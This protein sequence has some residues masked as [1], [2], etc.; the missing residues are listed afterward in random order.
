ME[1]TIIDNQY[2]N[3]SHGDGGLKTKELLDNLFFPL[4]SNRWLLKEEDS[5]ILKFGD[6]HLAF[7][8]DSFVVSPLVFPGG[9]IGKLA[10]C[11]TV[12]DLIMCGANP[13]YLSAS[14]IIPE[15][16][17]MKLLKEMVGSLAVLA[18]KHSIPV[19]TGDTKVTE[20]QNKENLFINTTGIG[21]IEDDYTLNMER[22]EPDDVVI[23]TGP[24]GDHGAAIMAARMDIG[25]ENSPVSDCAPLLSLL[26]SLSTYSRHIKLMRDP[27]RGG[28]AT[29]LKEI[30]LKGNVDMLIEETA[31]PVNPKVRAVSEILGLDPLYL[32]CEGRALVIV[33]RTSAP[34]IL[35]E[36]MR[37]NQT[38][39]ACAIGKVHKGNGNLLIK[40]RLGGTRRLQML[41]GSPLP[42]IC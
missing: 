24:I 30:C 4:L 17:E 34:D 3:L 9:N 5:A 22:L 19:V 41:S 32:A 35:H 28:V 14:F 10:F 15:G 2:V 16:M 11:G 33:S 37:N 25:I 7:S 20:S 12:N 1:G 40:T 36:L 38:N 31:I 29:T 8:T 39:G 21:L 23:V 18:E 42:R 27:T 13:K 6:M 26:D